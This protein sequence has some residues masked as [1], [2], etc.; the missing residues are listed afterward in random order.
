MLARSPKYDVLREGLRPHIL[1]LCRKL[2]PNGRATAGRWE[3]GNINGD[4]GRSL[5]V[6]LVG[7]DAGAWTDFATGEK[8][9]C[10]RLYAKI[11]GMSDAEAGERLAEEYRITLPATGKDRFVEA[12]RYTDETGQ[13]LFEVVRQKNP[14]TFPQRRP[15]GNGG[16]IWKVEGVRHVLYRLPEFKKELGTGNWICITEGEKDSNNL[17][18]LGV[19]ATTSPGGAAETGKC[20]WLSEF[21]ELFRDERVLLFPDNDPAGRKHMDDIAAQLNGIAREIRIIDIAKHWPECPPKGDISD[22][23][24]AGGG[25]RDKL[26]E[27]RDSVSPW[28][29]SKEP[30][31][32]SADTVEAIVAE[33][34][35]SFAVI[36]AGDRVGV[37]QEIDNGFRILGI[38][39]FKCWLANQREVMR[40][41]RP[42]ARS[43]FWLEHPARRQYQSIVFA[44][45]IIVPRVYNLWHGFAVEPRPGNCEKFLAHLRDNVCR[46]DP[47][48]YQ[49]VEAWFADIF[50]NPGT[51]PGSS[52]AIRGEPG[53]GKT[54]IGEVIGSLLGRHYL[55]VSDQRWVTGQFN[56]HLVACLLL[57][58]DEAFWAGDL[59]AEGKIKDLITGHEQLIEF[60]GKEPVRVANHL[61]FLVTGNPSWIVPAA[62]RERRFAVLEIGEDHRQDH[63][64]FAA[65][66][67]EMNAGGREALLCH[68]LKNV[69]L[70]RVN[71][72]QIPQTAA[73]LEQKVASMTLEQGWWMEILKNGTL[74]GD[75][76]GN[77]KAPTDLLY[78]HYIEHSKCRGSVRRS[79]ETQ[80]GNFLHDMVP[81]LTKPK[82]TYRY[83]ERGTEKTKRGYVYAFPPLSEC[84]HAFSQKLGGSDLPWDDDDSWTPDSKP[85][86]P[87]YGPY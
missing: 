27:I 12:Y 15:D 2:L 54:K 22:W 81:G 80:L 14:K 87:A 28:Q 32:E 17:V 31:A 85:Q 39:G 25:T 23:L 73:L 42:V 62:L 82:T 5:S 61:R 44:P 83:Y 64:Y 77:G 71:L 69:D 70:T 43:K 48:L 59:S 36:I 19:N 86:P 1:S 58:A 16:W 13:L 84:R 38:D 47:V 53:T 78:Q 4:K 65:I 74:P 8:G 6:K 21:N 75:W 52:L 72:R 35:K 40:N 18:A 49:W 63:R 50:Q 29:P 20:K 7:D 3:V 33:I 24:T 26:A 56:S 76:D 60:K 55:G 79:I 67:A 45:G 41:R 11:K 57:H 30:P 34:N 37:L 10:I 51:K 68:F 66:D 9:D 46:G